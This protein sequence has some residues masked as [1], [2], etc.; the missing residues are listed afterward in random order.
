MFTIAHLTAV[1]DVISEKVAAEVA[2]G[3]ASKATTAED[4]NAS[5]AKQAEVMS[6]LP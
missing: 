4:L 5:H 1:T 2:S 6:P 3:P